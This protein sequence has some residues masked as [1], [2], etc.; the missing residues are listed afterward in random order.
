[1]SQL[2]IGTF[3]NDLL[4]YVFCQAEPKD[5]KQLIIWSL[6]N[7]Q[8]NFCSGDISLWRQFAEKHSIAKC[9]TGAQ[10]K[11]ALIDI[12]RREFNPEQSWSLFSSHQV[13]TKFTDSSCSLSNMDS[14]D[15]PVKPCGS[16]LPITFNN[17][18]CSIEI[19]KKV[20]VFLH[21]KDE[22]SNTVV[23][24]IRFKGYADKS[25]LSDIRFT[26]DVMTYPYPQDCDV[27]L[28]DDVLVCY[29][30]SN[31]DC[32][33]LAMGYLDNNHNSA[34]F[35]MGYPN[36]TNGFAIEKA[37][38]YLI[39]QGLDPITWELSKGVSLILHSSALK[40]LIMQMICITFSMLMKPSML[41]LRSCLL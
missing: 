9:T 28:N 23:D 37:C 7:Q 32:I 38:R 24:T 20:G 29:D 17:K 25:P 40:T 41:T 14:P 39:Y 11:Q 26:P 12:A 19:R 16:R 10:V 4:R 2:S 1:M 8:F 15:R 3:P 5:V 22:N 21:I 35:I 27:Q 18:T 33:T 6:V 30:A 31:H 36:L 13:Y 34:E